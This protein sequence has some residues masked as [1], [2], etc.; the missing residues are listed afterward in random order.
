M[1]SD[2]TPRIKICGITRAEDGLAA[3]YAGADAIGMVFYEP[4]PR[5]VTIR[6]ADEILSVLPPFV[7][8]VAL[9]VNP[10]RDYVE[11]VLGS[12][13]IDLLQFHGDEAEDFCASF[14]CPY[15]KAARVKAGLDLVEYEVR[16]PTARGILLDAFTEQVYGGSGEQ[17][18]WKLIPAMLKKP[19]VLAGGLTPENVASAVTTVRPWAVDVSGGVD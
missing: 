13:S 17:F 14:D 18:D 4:S 2:M 12:V 15:V 9:F 7:T 10:A 8:T 19:F 1:K 16:Y 5:A 11:R 3:A 6:Q